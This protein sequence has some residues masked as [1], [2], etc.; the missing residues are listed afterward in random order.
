MEQTTT[1]SQINLF[2]ENLPSL[3]EIKQLALLVNSSEAN[4]IAFAE[5]VEANMSSDPQRCF[6][7]LASAFTS[8]VETREAVANFKRQK[9]ARKSSFTWPLRLRNLGKYD[10]AIENLKKSLDHQADQLASASKKWR[11]IALPAT[12]RQRKRTKSLRKL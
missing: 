2:A 12:S 1:Q 9:T 11:R 8:S 7:P 6:L 3:D 4:Q 5:Q 10:E